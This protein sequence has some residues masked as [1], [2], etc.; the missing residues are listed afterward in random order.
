MPRAVLRASPIRAA[1]Q[2]VF[3]AMTGAAALVL[4]AWIAPH[5]WQTVKDPW[6]APS[7]ALSSP[8]ATPHGS[9][10][11]QGSGKP[12][13]P[14]GMKKRERVKEYFPL[15][16]A[17][18]T[19]EDDVPGAQ[20]RVCTSEGGVASTSGGP[21]GKWS[22][23]G[24]PGSGLVGELGNDP[25]GASNPWGYGSSYGSSGA[26]SWGT[27]T[28]TPGT[29]DPT[30]VTTTTTDDPA[31]PLPVEPAPQLAPPP[32]PV[33]TTTPAE[34]A[35]AATAAG[36]ADPTT[37][38]TATSTP[39]GPS[40]IDAPPPE[41]SSLAFPTPWKS[42]L[43]LCAAAFALILFSRAVRRALTLRHLARPFWSESFD[44]R[45]SNHWERM[46]VG[47]R[48]AGLEPGKDEQPL[49]FARRVGIEG[50]EACATILERVRHGVRVD[51]G[52]LANMSASAEAAFRA[53]RER[54]GLVGRATAWLRPPTA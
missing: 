44:Q 31:P 19:D 10:Y 4:T 3:S 50:M 6:H 43:A 18:D 51:A 15:Q 34:T 5:L 42:S 40:P 11:A 46:L 29:T 7:S 2:H 48:D 49:T 53:A 17:H 32:T 23:G 26:G 39:H 54:A 37:T 38:T 14:I 36:T 25:F 20:C 33:E 28:T 16:R 12:C 35:T 13:C 52:D 45:I 22:Y 8:Y 1:G 21:R 27:P 41:G 9:A 47:L 24:T 30:T